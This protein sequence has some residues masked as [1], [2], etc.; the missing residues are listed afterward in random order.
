MEN[1]GRIMSAL[2]SN[3]AENANLKH[4]QKYVHYTKIMSN[5]ITGKPPKDIKEALKE[6]TK[7]DG[8]MN[9]AETAKELKEMMKL[10]P[11]DAAVTH[12][13]EFGP[14]RWVLKK[15]SRAT[16]NSEMCDY[17]VKYYGMNKL[18][19]N[20]LIQSARRELNKHIKTLVDTVAARNVNYLYEIIDECLDQ[21]IY[22]TAINA[23]KELNK[24]TG[25]VQ[26]PQ[27]QVTIAKNQQGE[28][29]INIT[30]DS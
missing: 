19:A 25:V 14:R 23:I 20:L 30:F 18:N 8:K 27:N 5:V 3:H 13:D 29:M 7:N 16:T 9:A 10:I 12:V 28:E 15:L 11:A 4:S 2:H 6:K 24:M 26:Q 22:D 1:T 21:K 17:L